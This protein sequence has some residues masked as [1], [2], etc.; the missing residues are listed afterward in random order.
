M[1]RNTLLNRALIGTTLSLAAAVTGCSSRGSV[2][3]ADSTRAAPNE[4]EQ[5][6]PIPPLERIHL[7]TLPAGTLLRVRTTSTVSTRANRAGE[8]FR[9]S[10]EDSLVTN[11]L[12]VAPRGS[13]VTVEIT[14]SNKGG[15]IKGRAHIALRLLSINSAGF[16][17]SIFT[18]TLWYQARGT[19]RKD[20]AKIGAG[21]GFGAGIGAI[22]GGGIGAAV[23]AGAGAG[24]GGIVVLAT[25]GDPAVVP[26]ES[27]LQFRLRE[28][29]TI[30]IRS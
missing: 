21:S 8:T 10:L 25:R 7:A 1:Y 15:R 16:H 13:D 23:G 27:V 12:V 24:A 6:V 19:K 28:P 29:L 22:A 26:S 14:D 17:R 2:A 20:F 4:V 18:N 9:A 3:L 30:E 5:R 11:G